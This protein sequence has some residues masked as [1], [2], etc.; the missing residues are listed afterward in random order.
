MS[1]ANKMARR[2]GAEAFKLGMSEE[3]NPYEASTGG[4]R[5]PRWHWNDAWWQEHCH[6]ADLVGG[7]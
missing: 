4:E 3:S 5:G 1:E 7:R 2:E 6:S